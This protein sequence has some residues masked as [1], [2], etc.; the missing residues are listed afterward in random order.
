[1]NTVVPIQQLPA[2]YLPV[3]K[4]A[5]ELPAGTYGVVTWTDQRPKLVSAPVG[6]TTVGASRL[7]DACRGL[8]GCRTF[9][10]RRGR[11]CVTVHT[12][13]MTQPGNLIGTTAAPAAESALTGRTARDDYWTALINAVLPSTA[14]Q[15]DHDSN[16]VAAMRRVHQ[17]GAGVPADTVW[18]IALREPRDGNAY[19]TAFIELLYDGDTTAPAGAR[20]L[21]GRLYATHV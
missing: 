6:L 21:D 4:A 19:L 3:A 5:E 9:V 8:Y 20:H 14:T 17:L 11:D 2:E 16:I 12:A 1:M 7:A 13:D 15:L 18:T 10:V